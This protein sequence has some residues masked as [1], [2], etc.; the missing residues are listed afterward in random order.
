M[1]PERQIKL[2]WV[3]PALVVAAFEDTAKIKTLADLP[4]GYHV[5]GA[6]YSPE[7]GAFGFHIYHPSFS[8]V[9]LG[10][11]PDTIST[12]TTATG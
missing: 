9:A 11:M 5:A 8:E 2:L 6:F 7:S 10:A 3:P 12:T 1:N 4:E